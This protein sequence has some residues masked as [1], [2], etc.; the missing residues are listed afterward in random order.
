MSDNNL[1]DVSDSSPSPL[2]RVKDGSAFEVSRGLP[3]SLS[4]GEASALAPVHLQL[5]TGDSAD[6]R[7]S[8]TTNNVTSL[9]QYAAQAQIECAKAEAEARIACAEA[10]KLSRIGVASAESALP[11]KHKAETEIALSKHSLYKSAM[12]AVV[13]IIGLLITKG[14]IG[15]HTAYVLMA[16]IGAIGARQ[17]IHAWRRKAVEPGGDSPDKPDAPK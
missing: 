17:T 6:A 13:V 9:D 14:Q 15:Q 1:P 5:M 12:L 4:S 2:V 11:A 8:I 16:G 10:E 7:F 3:S